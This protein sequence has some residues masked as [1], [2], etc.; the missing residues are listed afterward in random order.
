MKFLLSFF[1]FNFLCVW[2]FGFE[3][4]EGQDIFC[5]EILPLP[6]VIENQ[7]AYTNQEATVYGFADELNTIGVII[8]RFRLEALDAG[9]CVDRIVATAG[10][11]IGNRRFRFRIET[12]VRNV[13]GILLTTLLNDDEQAVLLEYSDDGTPATSSPNQ[14]RIIPDTTFAG[15]TYEKVIAIDFADEPGVNG[16]HRLFYHNTGGLLRAEGADGAAV[17]RVE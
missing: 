1:A 4:C 13:S 7:V 17:F 9:G 12:Q 6:Q 2:C 3:D 14:L 10:G 16:L 5:E 11:S 15:V 8:G